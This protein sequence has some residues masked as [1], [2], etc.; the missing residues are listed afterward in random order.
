MMGTWQP[1]VMGMPGMAYGLQPGMMAMPPGA[2]APGTGMPTG[3][4]VGYMP[5]PMMP[6][7]MRP[8]VTYPPSTFGTSLQAGSS[9]RQWQRDAVLSWGRKVWFWS[10]F[11]RGQGLLHPCRPLIGP[12][13]HPQVH[14]VL[15]SRDY[16]LETRVHSSRSR[17]RDLKSKVSV[18]VSR[19]IDPGLG[20]G[21]KTAC[22]VPTPVARLP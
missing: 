13:S 1:G 10:M 7:G 18:L 5:Q 19:P 20:L 4:P 3:P 8:T 6:A 15:W 11:H 22:L 9:L 16:G 21:L 2:V 17:S 14:P 12:I